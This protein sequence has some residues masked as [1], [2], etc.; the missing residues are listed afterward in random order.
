MRRATR[1]IAV[2]ALAIALTLAPSSWALAQ[3]DEDEE[4]EESGPAE[5]EDE[6]PEDGD[7]EEASEQDEGEEG[8]E[9]EAEEG[10]GGETGE[11][12]AE[13]SPLPAAR[14]WFFGPYF[15]YVFVPAFMLELFLDEAPTVANPAFGVAANYRTDDGPV[16]EIGLGFTSYAFEDPFRAKGD[17]VEDTEWVDSS[18]GMVHVTGSIM[19]VAEISDK[20]A[21]DY[22]IGLDLGIMTGSLVRTEAYQGS[23]G[24]QPCDA[25]GQPP[26][27]I[28]YCEFPNRQGIATNRYD[29][30]G[31]HY[32]VEE[33]RVPPVGLVP[34]IPHLALRFD[35]IEEFTVKLEAAYG[36]AQI[37][38]G[39]S[40]AYAP[41][42]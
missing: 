13:D 19:W 7:V 11:D 33:E 3:D 29:E 8:E 10:E 42:L 26:L 12:E 37:W 32:G 15:R 23:G 9:D 18:L 5:D 38:L 14:K 39:L 34:M 24:W 20:L 35:P 30:E 31:A 16:F 36:I 6:N 21:L 41:E 40:A 1:G 25:A 27:A 2:T 22:G 17:P 28:G 4:A